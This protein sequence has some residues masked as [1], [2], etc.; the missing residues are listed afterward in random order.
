[1]ATYL[2][3]LQWLAGAERHAPAS[4]EAVC[5]T[6]APTT[7]PAS[8]REDVAEEI[9]D[10]AEPAADAKPPPTA[11]GEGSHDGRV[12]GLSHHELDDLAVRFGQ[13]GGRALLALIYRLS[14]IESELAALRDLIERGAAAQAE[15]ANGGNTLINQAGPQFAVDDPLGL[16]EQV[17]KS[18][19]ALWIS[20]D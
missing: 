19:L 8:G 10:S 6:H 16:L 17:F 3:S 18:N 2:V 14:S 12:L 15:P 5:G 20:M 1:M 7:M 4:E 13:S 9:S 11:T